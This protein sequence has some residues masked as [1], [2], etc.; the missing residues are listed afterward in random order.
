MSERYPGRTKQIWEARERGETRA[1]I[2]REHGISAERVRQ[3]LA[4]EELRRKRKQQ[5]AG[6]ER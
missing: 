4:K 2:A 6:N 5:E 1:A 3:I